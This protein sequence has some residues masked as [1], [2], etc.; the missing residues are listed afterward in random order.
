MCSRRPASNTSAS[1]R[2]F[3]DEVGL[4]DEDAAGNP[5]YNFSYVDQIYDGLLQNGVR[6]FV[7]LSFMP[8]K[9]AAQQILSV[10]LVPSRSFRPPRTGRN[11]PT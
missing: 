5:I 1:T 4:Y 7:E 6:P 2:S 10:V 9:L 3:D 11:G 8:T